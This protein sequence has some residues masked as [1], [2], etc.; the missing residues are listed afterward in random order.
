[1]ERVDGSVPYYRFSGWDGLTHAVFTRHGGVSPAPWASLNTGGTV[2]D[3]TDNVHA[4]HAIMYEALKVDGAR[5][6]TVWQVHGAD[7]VYA[8]APV[9]NRRWL[10]P[11]DAMIT[12]RVGLP[13]VMRYADCT[14]VFAYDPVKGAIGIAHAGWRGTVSGMASRMIAAMVTAFDSRP[15]DIR[16]GVGPAIGPDRYQV[17]EEVVAAAQAHFGSTEGIIRR[18]PSDGTAYF[19]LWEANRR[20]LASAGVEQIEVMGLC[21]AKRTDDFFS[22]RAE[23]GSTGRFGAIICL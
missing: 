17:G 21:T 6:V 5:A 1:M 20:D 3:P 7:T 19:D 23:N 13:L 9:A 15:S 8:S 12:D 18:D 4:N 2:G 14:P 22:H 10:A 16:A 11:A